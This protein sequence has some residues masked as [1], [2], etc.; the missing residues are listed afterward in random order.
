M[1][2][3]NLLTI[4]AYALHWLTLWL[5]TRLSQN[6]KRVILVNMLPQL[7]YSIFFQYMLQEESSNGSGL[8]WW[9]YLLFVIGIHW[10]IN[11]TQ[12]VILMLK[13]RK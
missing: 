11:S 3:D 9:F 6:K 4:G 10:G 5:L 13:R 7:T 12:L 8:L 2:T 1:T